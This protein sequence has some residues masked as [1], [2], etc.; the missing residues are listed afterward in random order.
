MISSKN[1]S[2]LENN[3]NNQI[4]LLKSNFSK[5]KDDLIQENLDLLNYLLIY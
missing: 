1:D 3:S 4:K 5:N 2:G